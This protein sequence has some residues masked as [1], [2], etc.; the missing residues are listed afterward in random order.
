MKTIYHHLHFINRN[1]NSIEYY[2]GEYNS[3]GEFNGVGIHLFDKICIYIGQ[4]KND[5]YNGQGLLISNEG[6]SLFGDFVNEECTG[7]T[8]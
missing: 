8:I 5:Q 7:I 4:F 2:E 6:N 1:D 3:N